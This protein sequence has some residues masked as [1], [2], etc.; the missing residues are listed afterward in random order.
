[1]TGTVGVTMTAESESKPESTSPTAAKAS[2]TAPSTST[3]VDHPLKTPESALANLAAENREL[4]KLLEQAPVQ[5]GPTTCAAPD[6]S[7]P[8]APMSAL[9]TPSL[10]LVSRIVPVKI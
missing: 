5:K 3:K 9:A 6:K 10:S 1:M 2:C 8:A 7:S 4:R